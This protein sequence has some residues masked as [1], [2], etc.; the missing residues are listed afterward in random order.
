MEACP[1]INHLMVYDWHEDLG[2]P[3][4]ARCWH[5]REFVKEH[6]LVGRYDI[7]LNPRWDE[8]SYDAGAIAYFTE[9]PCR[10]AWSEKVLPRKAESNLGFDEFYTLTLQDR[11]I[12]HEVEHNLQFLTQLGVRVAL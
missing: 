7:V 10:V 3:L 11:R 1:Y 9:A 4:R 2:W 12:C 6:G 8:D 5:A